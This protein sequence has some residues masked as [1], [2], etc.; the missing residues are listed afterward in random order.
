MV[1]M[2]RAV[3]AVIA[4]HVLA[5]R[6]LVFVHF[7][8]VASLGYGEVINRDDVVACIRRSRDLLAR[9]TVA[10]DMSGRIADRRPDVEA[11]SAAMARAPI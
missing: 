5:A 3:V 6:A 4:R 1:D 10:D 9:V 2:A 8:T 11:D 7:Q